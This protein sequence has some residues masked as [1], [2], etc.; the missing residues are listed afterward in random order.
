MGSI[1]NFQM[2]FAGQV[3]VTPRRGKLTCT[4]FTLNQITTAG[5]LS[6]TNTSGTQLSPTDIID[7]VYSTTSSLTSPSFVQLNPSI[8]SSTG[9]ITLVPIGPSVT[10]PT[11]ANHIATYTNTEGGLGEDAGTAINGGNLQAGLSGTAGYVASFPSTASKGSLRMTAVA[12]TGNTL[13]TISNA[14]MGQASVI[15]IPD[16]AGA[17]ANFVV[18]PSALVNGNFIKASGTAGLAA[19]AGFSVPASDASANADATT[20]AVP[21]SS[22]GSAVLS[23][24]NTLP[25][26]ATGSFSLAQ[27]QGAFTTPVEIIPAPGSGLMVLVHWFALQLIYGSAA[28]SGG[29][30]A[31]LQYGNTAH[32]TNYATGSAAIP[33]AFYTGLAANSAISTTGQ[34]NST[35]GLATSVCGN[36]AI[37]YTNATAVF[38]S[39]TGGSGKWYCL[40]SIVPIT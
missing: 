13:T 5:F 30:A 12:N 11:I 6:N 4:G 28:Y 18:A 38:T 22:N 19:D 14:A 17:T 2:N 34:I 24:A 27:V 33:A 15:S 9:V 8:N 3:D 25:R 37:T 20:I 31:Y 16:P 35:T 21:M 26:F 36:A 29:G 39:G 23:F 7:C 10:T 40:Y 32:G 1:V